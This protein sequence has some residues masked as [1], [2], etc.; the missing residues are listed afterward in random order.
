MPP[1]QQGSAPSQLPSP[2]IT[3][4]SRAPPAR[5]E[6]RTQTTHV[7]PQELVGASPSRDYKPAF[8]A[9]LG[10]S[11]PVPRVAC[12]PPSPGLC[13]SVLWLSQSSHSGGT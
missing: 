2:A 13:V 5:V 12:T 7:L 1:T 8:G 11:A 3:Q 10:L 4:N 6:L 9:L